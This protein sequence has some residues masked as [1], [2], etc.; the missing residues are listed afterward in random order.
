MFNILII[1]ILLVRTLRYIFEREK[2]SKHTIILICC[3]V[4]LCVLTF[5]GPCCNVRYDL[6][7]KT[8]F[9]SSLPPVGC[10]KVHVLFTLFVVCLRCGDVR[11]VLCC[12]FVFLRIVCPVLPVSLNCPF[13]IAPSVFSNDYFHGDLKYYNCKLKHNNKGYNYIW[14]TVVLFQYQFNLHSSQD[15]PCCLVQQLVYH[16]VAGCQECDNGWLIGWCETPT[17]AIF[18]LYRDDEHLICSCTKILP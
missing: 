6:R 3:V 10:R 8:M 11:H 9:G 15:I 1:I 14:K 17:L 16:L 4:L 7:M 2:T 12:V 13:L 5:W 18:Q